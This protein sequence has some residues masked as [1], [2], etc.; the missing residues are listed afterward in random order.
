[1]KR[2][3]MVKKV[4][5]KCFS[6]FIAVFVLSS[7]LYAQEQDNTNSNSLKDDVTA[8]ITNAKKVPHTI[9]VLDTSESMNTFAYSDYIDTCADGIANLEKAIILCKNSY[10]QCRNVQQNVNCD[11]GFDCANVI[12]KCNE[13]ENSKVTMK[14]FC[15]KI[16]DTYPEPSSRGDAVDLQSDAALKYVGPWNPGRHYKQDLC[17]YDWSKDSNGDVLNETN[18][19]HWSYNSDEVKDYTYNSSTNTYDLVTDRRD[20]DC[21]T[22]GKDTM[23]NGQALSDL[24]DG[25]SGHWLN[26]KYA[27]SLD[28]VK[29]I[30]A[31]AHEFS[32]PPRTR[33]QS[34]CYGTEFLP[35]APAGSTDK[36][37]CF[38]YFDTNFT[39]ADADENVPEK[40]KERQEQLIAMREAVSKYWISNRKQTC[41]DNSVCTDEVFEDTKCQDFTFATDF[42]VPVKDVEEQF[43]QNSDSC[44]KCMEWDKESKV[45]KD[46]L[47][48]EFVSNEDGVHDPDT[49]A[50]TL[51]TAS[52]NLD[53]KTCCKTF[54]CTNPKCRD[55]DQ[56]CKDDP[57][58]KECILGYYSEYDQDENHCC[59][60]ITCAEDGV[61]VTPDNDCD[62]CQN[63]SPLGD[64]SKTTPADN[65]VTK[66]IIGAPNCGTGIYQSEIPVTIGLTGMTGFSSN[67]VES[68]TVVV[69]Y[70]C[71]GETS[72]KDSLG[73]FTCNSA[74]T[75][76]AN[77]SIISGTLSGCENKGYD[78]KAGIEV[79]RNTCKFS[80]ITVSADLNYKIGGY[81]CGGDTDK[82]L[83]KPGTPYYQIFR[84]ETSGDSP[85]VNEYECKTA[86]YHR[87]SITVDGTKCPSPDEAPAYLNAANENSNLEYCDPNSTEHHNIS[88]LCGPR[89]MLCSWLCRDAIVYD[90]PWKCTAFF[91]M[92]DDKDLHNGQNIEAGECGHACQLASGG[93]ASVIEGDETYYS[94]NNSK[95]EQCCA[96]LD[97]MNSTVNY[98]K[99]EEPETVEMQCR[100]YSDGTKCDGHKN[101]KCYVSGYEFGTA[102]NGQ[103]T[104]TSGY[105]AEIV[106]GHTKEDGS[107]SHL[108]S[109]YKE[110]YNPTEDTKDGKVLDDK[111]KLYFSPYDG[112]YEQHSL[113]VKGEAFVK[114]SF[115]SAFKTSDV[116]K[117][118]IACVYDLMYNWSGTDCCAAGPCCT[119]DYGDGDNGCEYPNFWMKVPRGDGGERIFGAEDLSNNTSIDE[120]R[121]KI[122]GL[123]AKGGSTLG[124][125]LYDVWRYLGGMYSVYDPEH[126]PSTNNPYL[127]PFE[128]QDPACFTNEAIVISGGQPQFD[129]NSDIADKT[130]FPN[131]PFT[132]CE[133]DGTPCVEHE[134]ET[135][136]KLEPYYEKD[137]YKTSFLKV[138]KFANT[139]TFWG[140]KACRQENN[141]SC[142]L[143]GFNNNSAGCDCVEE[144]N[145]GNNKAVLNHV[146]SIAIGEWALAPLYTNINKNTDYLDNSVLKNAAT[147]TK[148]RY[149]ALTAEG[150]GTSGS[151]EGNFQ[152][153]TDLFTAM[154]DETQPTDIV[155]GRPHWTSSLVQPYDVEEKYRGPEAYVAG[156]VPIEG[157]VSRFWF[158][159]LKK[160]EID[161][162]Q[163]CPI[164]DEEGSKCGEW[165]KQTF[166]AQDCFAGT[167]DTGS[168]F[169]PTD[170][171]SVAQ[172]KKLMQGG[173]A[174]KLAE[175]IK[176][177][178]CSETPCFTSSPRNL[179]YDDGTSMKSLKNGISSIVSLFPA[180]FG[181][182]KV[183]RI[184]D[185]MA[186]YDAFKTLPSDRIKVRFSDKPTIKVKDPINID[187][188]GNEITIRPLLLGAIVH[189]KPIA[190]YYE[191]EKGKTTR[192]Y[193]GANDGML[194]A[195]DESGEEIYGY[196]PS[197]A[198][199]AI[200]NFAAS[201]SGIF[202][203]ATVD[204]PITL[205]HIDQS[206]DG[207]INGN[208]KAY[209]IFGY[210]RGATGYTVIDVSNP[211]SPE[212]VQNINTDGGYSFGKV[213]VFRKCAGTCSYAGDLDYYLA[214]PGGYDMCHDPSSLTNTTAI[215]TQI[216]CETLKGNKFR[217]FK[218]DKDNGKFDDDPIEIS[219]KMSSTDK[220]WL[221]TSFASVPFAV[222]TKGKAAIDTE[223]VYFTDLSGV[224][225]RV[226]VK[227]MDSAQWTAQMVFTPRSGSSLAQE[228]WQT[229]GRSY[230]ASNFFPPLEKYNPANSEEKL[231]IPVITGN[232][233]NP[234]YVEENRLIV[235]YDTIKKADGSTTTPAITYNT[236]NYLDN[237]DGK[238]GKKDNKIVDGKDGWKL[239]FAG[240]AEDKAGEKGITEPLITYDIF[241]GKQSIAKNSYS[242]AWNT[243]IPKKA[244]SCKNFGTS[245]NYERL[246]LDGTQAFAVGQNS[247]EASGVRGE[248][249]PSLCSNLASKEISLATGVGV[250]ATDT[251]YDL[252]FGA[253]A[254][255]YR[256]REMDVRANSTHII[257][258][259]EL[260]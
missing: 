61:S 10:Q 175:K 60:T 162:D 174:Y 250:I 130:K 65:E 30:L 238:A 190:V 21:L 228:N 249:D 84:Y 183:E 124:E 212:F 110:L 100:N 243:Y 78:L 69:Q 218:F 158:G 216:Y 90:D 45:F 248:W 46:T 112:W 83:L 17:F 236:D 2:N 147:A 49:E 113:L 131:T 189:S 213:V 134:N 231:P 206:H 255:I 135:P 117:R 76:A 104:T 16:E 105:M 43:I 191:T 254:D 240:P 178:T 227:N 36:V 121:N 42:P 86:F 74:E 119:L 71:K 109:P 163:T 77:D 96:C 3:A 172:F 123:K 79:K 29:I 210:R 141:L 136:N 95:L 171:S 177:V 157:S 181:Q 20:W 209:L 199:P 145:D 82:K 53:A 196:I 88:T 182:D 242:L 164:T 194:H 125:T 235:F 81:K 126:L 208:E 251:G 72:I 133:N 73:S 94:N 246:I 159:N 35:P 253:G 87:Q 15:K 54:K 31:S 4:F 241:G 80:E 229:S 55:D 252:T 26:W 66:N 222:N 187:F 75:C 106:T 58:P 62:Y 239:F 167:S 223:F 99:L 217:I 151:E 186:G 70:A 108:L 128:S 230:V 116:A 219:S 166:S 97:H 1:M 245:N 221:K 169:L 200:S 107:G 41:D 40:V 165:V 152:S 12:S 173:A 52:V 56:T 260:Y 51:G 5:L 143:Q 37:V 25:V 139:N 127:S 48:K 193:A 114:D 176:K 132:S 23:S 144:D 122:K 137:W 188:N 101:Y 67:T 98:K 32:N 11:I 247:V 195:F 258:W 50:T 201:S 154:M 168:D 259:Y 153:L 161:G 257:K 220:G 24:T 232:A 27:T 237:K 14:E 203:N 156:A 225:F 102:S 142:S 138:A 63:G 85:I 115:V 198:F 7:A 256:K 68:V 233:A 19:N 92:M 150:T 103:Q 192:I 93:A 111:D 129:H 160:Y 180:S 234:R 64:D 179:L 207:I 13:M 214:V 197:N 215:N 57:E 155:S 204:G 33:G 211:N 226:D 184:F 140:K 44:S 202:F 118:E 22:D 91:Y 244:T 39:L 205:L 149:Y 170:S 148:G 9:F 224:V 120:F 8:M 185:Y 47:C 59:G 89:R 38:T 28:A 18:T 6:V 34:K 146:H